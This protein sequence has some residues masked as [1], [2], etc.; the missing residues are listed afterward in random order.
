MRPR[1]VPPRLHPGGWSRLVVWLGLAGFVVWVYV[2]VV[3]G[4]GALIGRTDSPSVALS[5]VATTVVA[6]MFARVQ[7]AMEGATIRWGL[8]APPPYDVLSQFSDSVTS[9]YATG[10]LPA[11]MAMLLAQGTGATW[12]QV[13]LGVP[14]RLTLAATWPPDVDADRTPPLRADDTLVSDEGVRALPV[15]HGDELL[16]VLRL[17]ERPGL[18]LTLVEERLFAGLAAQS[19]LVLNWVRL[20]AELNDRHADLLVRSEEI[21]ASRE[22]LIETQDAER[23]RLERDLHDGAQQHLVGLEANLG[24][25]RALID[26]NP[27]QAQAILDELRGA[28]QEAMQDF[29]DLAHGIYPPLLQDRGLAEALANAARRTTVPTRVEPNTPCRYDPEVEATVYFCCLEALQNAAKHA[30]DSARATIRLYEEQDALL[31]E[32]TDDGSGFDPARTTF[33]AGLT[34][35]RDRLE[36][37]GGDLRID[38]SLGQGSRVLGTIPLKR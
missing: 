22:R 17:R 29:R 20:R 7:A 14:D 4:G 2:V 11:R 23:R 32:I 24:A 12:A 27:E 10:E 36:A 21:R 3:L 35:M 15:R 16:G 9:A 30:G 18:A 31:F 33:G 19:G 38:S 13:W 28:V 1:R 8:G 25:A 37:I 26:S 5:V 6:L 34:N